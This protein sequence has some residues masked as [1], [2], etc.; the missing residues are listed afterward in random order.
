MGMSGEQLGQL[1]GSIAGSFIP[2][3]GVGTAIGAGVG[4]AIG[5]AVD[6]DTGEPLPTQTGVDPSV[7]QDQSSADLQANAAQ[8]QPQQDPNQQMLQLLLM[9][10][11]QGPQ[12]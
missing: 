5:S 12:K 4:G 11:N 10:A 9:L 2:I 1:F 3:P 7:T 6:P 8:A